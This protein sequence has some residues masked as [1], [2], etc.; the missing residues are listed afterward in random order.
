ML[1]MTRGISPRPRTYR[2]RLISTPGWSPSQ[3]LRITP[4]FLAYTW[5][6]GPIVAS[7]SVFI[8]TTCLRLLKASVTMCAPNSTAPVT[9]TSASIRRS[10]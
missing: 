3:A 1:P 6:I 10:G 5:R 9:S 4:A 7:S 2:N 8:R